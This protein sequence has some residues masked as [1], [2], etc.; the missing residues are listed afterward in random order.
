MVE[1]VPASDA[2]RGAV[3]EASAVDAP[4]PR[5]PQPLTASATTFA[6]VLNALWGGNAVAIK[7]GL[8]DA[9]PLRLAALRFVAGGVVTVAWAIST[10][11]SLW[12]TRREWRP[13]AWLAVLFVT[14]IA[15]MN[16]GQDHTTAAH[17]VVVNTTYPLWTGVFAHFFV[18]GDRLSVG[19][20]AGTVIAYGGVVVLF[21]QSLTGG[22]TL[23]GDALMLCSASMLGARQVYTSLAAQGV[24]LPKLLLTQT[25]CGIAAFAIAGLLIE[26]DTWLVTDRLVLSILYQGVVIAGFGFIGNM[27]LIKHFLPSAV[28]A[29]SLTTPVWGV[30]LSHFVLGEALAPTLFVGLALVIA[31]S[32]LAHWSRA[33]IGAARAA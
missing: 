4:S 28:T 29:L 3:V 10:R 23:T 8:R 25:V 31:G 24:G 15:F 22:G 2:A 6:L 20:A 5:G 30:I 21:A 9:P 14:Q 18:P 12:P 19:R 33:R 16:I 26:R 1:A 17:A 7:A 13:L 27:W 32:A 11:Q